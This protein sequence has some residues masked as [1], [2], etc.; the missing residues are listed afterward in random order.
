MKLIFLATVGLEAL[1]GGEL[2][3]KAMRTNESSDC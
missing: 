3:D 2:L 1:L